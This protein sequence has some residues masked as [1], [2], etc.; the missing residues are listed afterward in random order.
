MTTW[1]IELHMA[2]LFGLPYRIFVCVLGLVIVMLSV[3]G[4]YI[5]WKKRRRALASCPAEAARR[6]RE[7]YPSLRA[8]R[9]NRRIVGAFWIAPEHAPRIAGDLSQLRDRNDE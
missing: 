9:S 7:I 2:N 8:E 1:L 4:V 6:T 3:T 5:W